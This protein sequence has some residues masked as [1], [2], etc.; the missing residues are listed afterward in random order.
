VSS[1]ASTSSPPHPSVGEKQRWL[2]L[3]LLFSC[4][5]PL[6]GC[7]SLET[8]APPV[9][10]ALAARAH[11]D[12]SFLVTGRGI[13]T[14]QCAACH[15]PESVPAHAGEWPRIIAEMAPKAKLTPEQQRAVLAYVLAAARGSH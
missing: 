6:A 7:A 5:L 10:P 8:L 12:A 15:A 9:T 11:T 14:R 1:S 13:Y 2:R 3:A 4:V